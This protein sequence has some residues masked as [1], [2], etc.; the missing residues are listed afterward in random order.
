MIIIVNNFP[1]F[2]QEIKIVKKWSWRPT[3]GLA[4]N[5]PNK[6]LQTFFKGTQTNFMRYVYLSPN[7]EYAVLVVSEEESKVINSLTQL[8]TAL[9][10]EL[11]F[12]DI[13]NSKEIKRLT[14]DFSDENLS[15]AKKIKNPSQGYHWIGIRIS[16]I[17]FNDEENEVYINFKTEEALEDKITIRLFSSDK[18]KINIPENLAFSLPTF[19]PVEPK[20]NNASQ[21]LYTSDFKYYIEDPHKST[22]IYDGET[23]QLINQ[24]MMPKVTKCFFQPEMKL[25]GQSF[26]NNFYVYDIDKNRYIVS[27]TFKENI[28]KLTCSSDGLKLIVGSRK[29]FEIFDLTNNSVISNYSNDKSIRYYKFIKQGELLCFRAR[30]DLYFFD[31]NNGE[32]VKT[33]PIKYSVAISS[34][35][36][37]YVTF[38]QNY[39]G[40]YVFD[41]E[42]L[43]QVDQF[44]EEPKGYTINNKFLILE[45]GKY[46]NHQT[47]KITNIDDIAGGNFHVSSNQLY[48]WIDKGGQLTFFD[49]KGLA[50]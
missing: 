10:Y 36:G 33:L 48:G 43:K 44:A 39:T 37:K 23:S 25:I 9:R 3:V 4:T 2:S 16:S 18:D 22:K 21:K 26:K 13:N 38:H 34:P 49:V 40:S 35:Y 12:A 11:Y 32:V 5:P 20:T 50:D 30:N 6:L 1:T 42:S 28:N 19:E 8:R 14:F 17:S 29:Y 27:S 24:L 45:G 46:Y 47:K 15:A 41:C 7:C 31:V